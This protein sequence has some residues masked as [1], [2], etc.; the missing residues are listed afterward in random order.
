MRGGAQVGAGNEFIKE[1]SYRFGL[2]GAA[3]GCQC[4]DGLIQIEGRD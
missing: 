3:E 4:F 1:L 2:S